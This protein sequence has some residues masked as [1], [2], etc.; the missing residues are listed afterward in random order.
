MRKL[1]HPNIVKYIEHFESSKHVYIIMT[2]CD[3]GSLETKIIDQYKVKAFTEYQVSQG[4]LITQII[5]II[6]SSS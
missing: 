6:S 3:G 1:T 2:Y 5:I 4:L